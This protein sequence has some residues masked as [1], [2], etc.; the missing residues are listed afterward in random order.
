MKTDATEAARDFYE[1]HEKDRKDDFWDPFVSRRFELRCSECGLEYP[2]NTT[3]ARR[4]RWSSSWKRVPAPSPRTMGKTVSAKLAR[5]FEHILWKTG[6][7]FFTCDRCG[8]QP[9][10]LRTVVRMKMV[11]TD[12]EE[13]AC[14]WQEFE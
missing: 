2:A 1:L 5:L 6:R 10:A 3:V 13:V 8:G 9:D 7:R 4:L 12:P 14:P 11:V